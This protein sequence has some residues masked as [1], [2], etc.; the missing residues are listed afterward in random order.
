MYQ[1]YIANKNYSSWSLRPWVLMTELRIAFQEQLLQFGDTARWASYRSISPAGKVP[2]LVD[3]DLTVWDTLSIAEYLAEHEA[4]VWP[5][6]TARAPGRAA[7][8]RK[9]IPDSRTAQSL[10][11][12]LRCARAA[13]RVSAIARQPISGGLDELWQQGLNRFG[14]PFLAG[15][16]SPPLMPSLRRWRSSADLWTVTRGQLVRLRREIAG[17]AFHATVVRA[18]ARGIL[19][20]HAARGG[21]C[22]APAG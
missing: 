8:P 16:A 18:G 9:C 10:L 11:D 2:C 13:Q 5:A 21:K 17:A 3:G 19:S 12:D 22:C 6:G 4:G 20:R 1:L 14:G 7:R 15:P